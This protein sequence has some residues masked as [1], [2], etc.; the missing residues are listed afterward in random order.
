[1]ASKIDVA[2]SLLSPPGDTLLEHIEHIG[3]TQAELAERMG[4][5]REKVNDI[6][7]GRE[8]ITTATAFQLENVL[9]IPAAF[10]LN[11]E[12]TYR[13]ECYALQRLEELEQEHAWLREFPIGEM[14]K[15]GWLPGS[16]EKHVLVDALLKFFGVAS[17]EEWE[18]IYTDEQMSVS[19]RISLAH[20]KSPH[21]MS[22]WLRKGE[23]QSQAMEIGEFDKGMFRN[24]LKEIKELAFHLPEGWATALQ[25]IG[26]RCGVAIVFTPPLPKAPISGATRWFHQRPIIQLSG[27][28]Q[29][30]DQF[31]FTF[32]HE[33]GHIMLHGKKDIFLEDAKGTNMDMQKEAEANAF[34]ES[35]LLPGAELQEILDAPPITEEKILSFAQ[36]FRTPP[37]V[38]VGR[39]QRLKKMPYSKANGLRRKIDLFVV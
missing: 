21:A 35:N 25:R 26:A 39:L 13:R 31:W 11:R 16:K 1:M 4:R 18:R 14:C 29:T 17:R 12:N 37:G 27:R 22:A 9:G 8:P 20:T 7:R 30:D 6:I 36:R 23:L 3:M 34:A 32:F 2:R 15:Q 5:P 33:A 24:A 38:I 10:W 28:F 19:F